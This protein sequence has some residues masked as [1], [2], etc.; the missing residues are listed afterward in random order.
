MM[1]VEMPRIAVTTAKYTQDIAA[2]WPNSNDLNAVSEM[3][4]LIEFRLK[5]SMIEYTV[6][7]RMSG[8][9]IGNVT[10]QKIS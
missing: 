8:V 5:E 2:L 10:F 6:F 1:A 7:V 3:R 4:E 9:I